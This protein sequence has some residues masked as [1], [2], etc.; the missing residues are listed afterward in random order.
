MAEERTLCV[1]LDM[2]RDGV[3]KVEEVKRYANLIKK[4]G[5][6]AL[7]LYMEDVYE[8]EGEP[9]FGHLRGRYTKAELKEINDY[10]KKIGMTA[11][12]FIQTL[13]HLEGIFKWDAYSD[14]RDIMNILLA[15]EEK[16]YAL[17]DKMFASL[18]ECFD[19]EKINIGMDEAPMMGRGKY[20]DKHGYPQSVQ[21]LL[22]EHL[23]KVSE[24]ADKHGF[25]PAMWSDLIMH[26]AENGDKP[27][28]P[29]NVTLCYWDYYHDSKK[30]YDGNLKKHLAVTDKVSFAGGAWAWTGFVPMN[31]HSIN[32]M[33]YAMQCC[34]ERDIKDVTITVWGDDGR[35]CSCFAVL[36]AL[37][38]CAEKYLY[39]T[40][41]SNI[42]KKF[43][44]VYGIKYDTFTSLDLP[45]KIKD[46]EK[47]NNPSRWGF[48]ND[49][50]A[51]RFD[52]HVE[53]GDGEIYKSHALKLKRA[54][55]G[56]GEFAYLFENLSELCKVLELKYDLGVRTR[57]AYL[58]EDKTELKR[59]AE[60]VYPELIKRLKKFIASFKASWNKENKPFGIELHEMRLGGLLL[61]L[62][63]CREV[64]LDYLGGKTDKIEELEAPVLP[65]IEGFGKTANLCFQSHINTVT[66]ANMNL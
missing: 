22:Y 14:I 50:L 46:C 25:K 4:A 11:I 66:V 17:I 64:I 7:G 44:E 30:H 55:K 54:A 42:K 45:N 16:T 24:I 2:S 32:T 21:R 62:E 59:I 29:E 60:V 36:P 52:Y 28:V 20:L 19:T 15:D 13:A 53:I 27:E 43:A 26:M 18:R 65:L 58:E 34:R 3:M 5:Y 9:Y 63:S 61:R 40:K 48:Y 8:I 47:C 10:C 6:N 41:D 39:Q 49:P 56:A 12:P 57:K 51:G 37:F 38:Y 33:K 23:V 35:D 1:M 31:G